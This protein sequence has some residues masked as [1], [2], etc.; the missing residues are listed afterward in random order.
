M[1]EL[2]YNQ[3]KHSGETAKSTLQEIATSLNTLIHDDVLEEKIRFGLKS[4]RYKNC[5][6]TIAIKK[7]ESRKTS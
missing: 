1:S 4:R 2:I 6:E 3:S 7:M 5:T